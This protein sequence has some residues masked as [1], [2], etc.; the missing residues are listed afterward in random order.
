MPQHR[1][2]P[3]HPHAGLPGALRAAGV[4]EADRQP[5]VHGQAR[6]LPRRHAAAGRAAGRASAHH[7]LFE[8]V[9]TLNQN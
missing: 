6:R 4:P 8:E 1:Q 5:A 7:Q 3:V 9:S 2:A